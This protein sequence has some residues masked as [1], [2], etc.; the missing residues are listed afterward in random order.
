MKISAP[1]GDM[2]GC[3]QN[4]MMQFLGIPYAKPPVGELRFLPAQ[5]FSHWD[6]VR[7]CTSRG[8]AAP[9]LFVPGLSKFQDG[10]TPDEDC[11]Y[12]DVT[13]PDISKPHP[14]LVWVHA[15]AFQR[16]SGMLGLN[17]FVF[18]KQGIVVV[19]VN[20]RLGVLGFMDVSDILGNDYI[21]SGNNGLLDVA[22]ALSWVKENVANF[23][24]DPDNVTI[25]GQSAGAKICSALTLMKG[26]KGLF[27]RAILCSGAAQSI[28]DVHTARCITERFM[29]D[30]KRYIKH[31]RDILTM[32][33]QQIVKAQQRLFSGL[34]LHT[35]GPVFD[36]VTF[37]GSDALAMIKEGASRGISLLIG[38]N[39][40]EMELY[41]HVY[42][43]SKLYEQLAERLFGN[44]SDIVMHAYRQIP[45][46]ENFHERFIHFFTEYVY[47]AGTLDMARAAAKAGQSVYL[48]RLDWDRQS[49]KACHTSETQF[50][51]DMN[52]VIQDPDRSAAHD[53]LKEDMQSDFLS[54]IKYGNPSEAGNVF[55]SAFDEAKQDMI[56]FDGPC[57]TQKAPAKET[58]PAMPY[59]VFALD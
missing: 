21:Q 53:T 59:Q 46:D 47:R 15:G 38:T 40:D 25:M 30:A 24:G 20:Y 3:V 22:A 33:W 17:P 45:K 11:L 26:A 49:Y 1:C 4:G 41:Y 2:E 57:R 34:N 50:L 27:R 8:H 19:D 51:M 43:V 10:E 6:G 48:Y 16:G 23:G 31:D 12:L 56:V 37:D 44:R 9:Q 54:F 55:W 58:D 13:T 28:R 36:G 52:G 29:Q 32:P 14:V 7:I 18:A 42:H 5:P 35:V 39:R